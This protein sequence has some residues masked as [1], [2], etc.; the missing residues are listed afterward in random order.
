MLV[1]Q[2]VR[3]SRRPRDGWAE[4]GAEVARKTV[5]KR[6]SSVGVQLHAGQ[7]CHLAGAATP[8]LPVLQRLAEDVGEVARARLPRG[9]A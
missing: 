7:S 8:F 5:R 4:E 2:V 6:P 9:D 3:R 1:T